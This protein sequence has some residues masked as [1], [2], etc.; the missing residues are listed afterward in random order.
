[1]YSK[2]KLQEIYEA[3]K[4][5]SNKSNDPELSELA[6]KLHAQISAMDDTADNSDDPGGNNPPP[7][8]VP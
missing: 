6:D 5:H 7:P 2:N 8:H 3:I 1:M 4:A